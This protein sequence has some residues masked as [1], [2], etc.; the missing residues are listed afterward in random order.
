MR[1]FQ[2]LV[3]VAVVIAAITLV[4]QAL[5]AIHWMVYR[6]YSQETHAIHIVMW[7]AG[8]GAVALCGLI[9]S[10]GNHWRRRP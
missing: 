7:A 2:F 4:V 1:A 8:I 3:S 9:V 10:T 6:N 5:D